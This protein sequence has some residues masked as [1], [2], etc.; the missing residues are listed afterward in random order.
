MPEIG[1]AHAISREEAIEL[2]WER[3]DLS[4][5]LRPE[6]VAFKNGIEFASNPLVVGNISRRLGKSFTLVTFAIEE[7]LKRKQKIRYGSAFLTDLEEFILPA[8]EIILADCPE[9]LRPRYMTSRKVWRFQNGSEIKLIGLDKNPNGLRGNAISIMIIDEAAF[10]QN[11]KKIYTSV[12]IPATMKQKNIRLIF[13]STPP[14][15]PAHYFVALIQRAK[16]EGYDLELTIDDISDLKP[17]ERK[18]VLDEVG[19][20]ESDTAQREFFCK[21]ISDPIR[22]V[23]P[24]FNESIHVAD[25][26]EPTHCNWAFVAD[27]GGLKDYAVG[28]LAAY[29]HELRKLVFWDES[30]FMN[31]T[32]TPEILEGFKKLENQRVTT[33]WIDAH[34]Q[35]QVDFA[36]AG[37]SAALPP[38]DNFQA[39]IQL[40][41]AAFHNNEILIHPRCK[42]LILTLKT[43][44]LNRLG[45]DYER[46]EELGHCDALAAAIYA[47]RVVDRVTDYRPNVI[48]QDRWIQQKAPAHH[49]ELQKLTFRGSKADSWRR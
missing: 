28:Y 27:I 39:G 15:S 32:P 1:A 16:L 4:Y 48:N 42:L 41:R 45:T 18:R 37:F 44:L 12:I 20:E 43:G 3:A 19:G 29:H 36:F 31:R 2:L 38:K 14:E 49:Q 9:H 25:C 11:L 8:F 24:T 22:A 21:I 46:T 5:L 17:E 40:I 35:T 34:G 13:I 30:W 47:V 26:P 7:A 33:R 10:V 6:Q 23:C